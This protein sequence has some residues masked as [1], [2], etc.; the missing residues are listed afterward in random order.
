MLLA[1][2][3]LPAHARNDEKVQA[4]HLVGDNERALVADHDAADR[5]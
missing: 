5:A 4:E 2:L 1:P 3:V